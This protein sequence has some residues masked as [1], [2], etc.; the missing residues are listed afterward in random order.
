MR[1][2]LIGTLLAV[3]AGASHYTCIDDEVAGE[4]MGETGVVC[5]PK[6]A[7]GTLDCPTDVPDGTTAQPQCMLTDVDKVGYCGLLCQVDTQCPSGGVC[8]RASSTKAGLCVHPLSFQ[9]WSRLAPKRKK[10]EPSLPAAGA[11]GSAKGFRLAKANEA[12]L[13][14]KQRFGIADG[15]AD[16]LVVQEMILAARAIDVANAGTASSGAPASLPQPQPQVQTLSAVQSAPAAPATPAQQDSVLGPWSK[17]ISYFAG[18]VQ[19]GIPGLQREI[20]DTVWNVEHLQQRGVASELLRSIVL[21][22]LLYLAVGSA[23]KYQSMGARGIDMIPHLGFWM[24][25]PGLVKDG[26]GYAQYLVLDMM[27]KDQRSTIIGGQ[28]GGMA[29]FQPKSSSE[30]DSFGNFEPSL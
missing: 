15:D 29:S 14:L 24:D 23:I 20:H 11:S 8:W 30:R 17:D 16:I 22:G 6:C 1:L 2:A 26:V 12:L 7:S 25:F 18:N 13:N 28:S 5:S 19:Q 10:L 3:A 21:V 9:E 27:G 4:L